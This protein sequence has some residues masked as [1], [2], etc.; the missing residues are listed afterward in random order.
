MQEPNLHEGL[1]ITQMLQNVSQF[2]SIGYVSTACF[3][4][5]TSFLKNTLRPC[6]IYGWVWTLCVHV[7]C[8]YLFTLFFVSSYLFTLF[9]VPSYL[10]TLFF[11]PSYLLTLFFVPSYLFTLFFFTCMQECLF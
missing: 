3:L 4:S 11:V 8:F 5:K 9:F 6:E 10:L 2:H 1:E 7:G